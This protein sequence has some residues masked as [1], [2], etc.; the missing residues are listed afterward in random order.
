MVLSE[1]QGSAWTDYFLFGNQRIVQQ[2]SSN[3]AAARL[4][5]HEPGAYTLDMSEAISR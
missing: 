1:K 3:L 4:L 5:K 2:T